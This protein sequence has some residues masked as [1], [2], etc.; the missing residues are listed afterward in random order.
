[1]RKNMIYFFGV[2]AILLL[3]VF[4]PVNYYRG[5]GHLISPAQGRTLGYPSKMDVG[6][7]FVYGIA[8]A[9]ITILLSKIQKR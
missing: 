2:V 4:H 9:G 6:A 5:D 8:I 1:M 7:T 3:M